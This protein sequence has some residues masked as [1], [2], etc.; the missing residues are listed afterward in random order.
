VKV[1]RAGRD[2]PVGPLPEFTLT[3]DKIPGKPVGVDID[4]QD[5]RS[6]YVVCVKEGPF[7]T[8]NKSTTMMRQLKVG[9]FIVKV[10][11]VQGK[12]SKL[13]E[14]MKQDD[15]LELVVRRPMEL[16]VAVCRTDTSQRVCEATNHPIGKAL[17]ITKINGGSCLAAW[18]LANPAKEVKAG[19]RIVAVDGRKGSAT[20]LKKMIE[21]SIVYQIT[22]VRPA[23][24]EN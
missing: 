12:G 14:Q 3:V 5:V 23:S 7:Q 13:M 9:D 20:D 24:S 19:D 21:A 8:Y 16:T 15:S 2:Y 10:N 17:L 1:K 6:A 4:I 22:V 18:N 11:G